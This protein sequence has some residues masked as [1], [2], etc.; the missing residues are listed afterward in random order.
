MFP[1]EG[2]VHPTVSHTAPLP[3]CQAGQKPRD[4]QIRDQPPLE[5]TGIFWSAQAWQ[6]LSPQGPGGHKA[7]KGKVGC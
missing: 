1:S 7:H 5:K 2:T 3:M 6:L 4:H